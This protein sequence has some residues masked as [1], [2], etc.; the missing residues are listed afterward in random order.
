MRW[1]DSLSGRIG[2][3]RSH[4]E[5]LEHE[6]KELQNK[7]V[8]L[9]QLQYAET[10]VYNVQTDKETGA[11]RIVRAQQMEDTWLGQQGSRGPDDI[12]EAAERIANARAKVHP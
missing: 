5:A 6:Q 7:V 8:L 1:F 12:L 2:A 11:Q 3:C 10:G 9:D 4:L